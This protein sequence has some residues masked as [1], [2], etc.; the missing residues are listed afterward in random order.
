MRKTLSS[1][2]RAIAV[3]DAFTVSDMERLEALRAWLAAYRLML[4]PRSAGRLGVK[5]RMSSFSD[6]DLRMLL[7][8]LCSD[9]YVAFCHEEKSLCNH[10][11]FEHGSLTHGPIQ[12]IVGMRSL[13]REQQKYIVL[14]VCLR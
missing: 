12:N 13:H 3:R 4:F 5:V 10:A 8:V 9:A 2:G 6:L 14:L 11:A 1:G 7:T